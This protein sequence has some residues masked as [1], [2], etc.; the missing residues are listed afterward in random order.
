MKKHNDLPVNIKKDHEVDIDDADLPVLYTG[1]V[2]KHGLT[3]LR[4]V[5]LKYLF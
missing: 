3:F 2:A 1:Y 4:I 5:N